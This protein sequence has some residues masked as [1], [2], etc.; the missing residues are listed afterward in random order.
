M[1]YVSCLGQFHDERD[2]VKINK[3]VYFH[4]KLIG[5]KHFYTTC[6]FIFMI[7]G[8]FSTM[9]QKKVKKFNFGSNDQMHYAD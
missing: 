9:R 6:K 4:C 2:K 8:Q 5:K 1:Q 3:Y 7:V